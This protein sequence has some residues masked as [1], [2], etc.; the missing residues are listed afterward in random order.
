MTKGETKYEGGAVQEHFRVS[1]ILTLR[2][3]REYGESPVGLTIFL[4]VQPLTWLLL[5]GSVFQGVVKLPGFPVNNYYSFLVP[6]VI[7]MTV[8]GYI[9][10]G[11]ACVLHDINS[12]FLFKMWSAPIRKLPIV[13]GRVTLMVMLSSFQTVVTLIVSLGLG[14]RIVTGI[15]GFLGILLLS[16]L[17]T[18]GLTAFSMGL[19]YILKQDFPFAV[20][21]SFIIFPVL[22]VSNAFFPV[23]LMPGW[24]QPIAGANPVTP[25]MTAM[26]DLVVS[27]IQFPVLANALAALLVFDFVAFAFALFVFRNRIG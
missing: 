2:W 5:F 4:L 9:A 21:T 19:A 23:N 7:A 22:F 3:L 11:G 8:L 27:G 18:V 13:T 1:W 12:G 25:M 6:G 24:L 10:L 17:L 16:D 20:V 15:W 26:R 14:V